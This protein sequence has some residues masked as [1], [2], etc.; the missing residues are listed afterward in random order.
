MD[1]SIIGPSWGQQEQWN[2][3]VE[4]RE[5][6]INVMFQFRRSNFRIFKVSFHLFNFAEKLWKVFSCLLIIN[7]LISK[8]GNQI[9]Y[10]DK[11]CE[12]GKSWMKNVFVMD[13]SRRIMPKVVGLF[14]WTIYKQ[15]S[16]SVIEFY[17]EKEATNSTL[18][19][20]P[21][22]CTSIFNLGKY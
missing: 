4:W 17:C 16:I 10:K 9:P 14:N 20:L 6:I 3:M 15:Y 18:E 8:V 19:L 12:V 2:E 21:F 5:E 11:V 7:Y 13:R 1:V 22:V